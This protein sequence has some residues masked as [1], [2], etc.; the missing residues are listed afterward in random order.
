MDL[1][2]LRESM[3]AKLTEQQEVGERVAAAMRAVPRHLFVPHVPPEEA[4]RDEP[5]VTRRDDAGRPTSSSSQPTIMAAML[6]QLDVRPGHRVLEIGAGTGYNAA[7]LARL[8]EPGGLVVCLDI[9]ADITAEARAHL[10]EAGLPQ[11]EVVCGD[12]AEG[13]PE[14][15]P[16]DR[17]IATVGV[18][19]LAPA[20]TEQLAP[21]GRLVVPLDVNGLQ[22]SVALERDGGRWTSRSVLPCGFMRMRGPLSGT[23]VTEVVSRDPYVVMSLPEPREL[24]DV[25]AAL[26]DT[27]AELSLDGLLSDPDTPQDGGPWDAGHRTG[28]PMWLALHEPRWCT[29][30]GAGH[31]FSAGIA[32]PGGLA[33]LPLHGDPVVRGH[34]PDGERLARELAAHVRAWTGAGRPQPAGLRIDAYPAGTDV[35]GPLVL[36]K[37]HT[38]LAVTLPS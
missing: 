14:R 33:L 32:E 29:V 23:E 17:L 4:Y 20:W 25:A 37:R 38:A 9:D 7:L 34:G 19:D 18:W 22:L 36:R 16:Y 8:A 35:S 2:G 1:T 24:G 10:D 27:A 6:D 28:V 3:V 5:I 13:H 26:G 11:V 15:A 12:G 30:M 31:G 21:G